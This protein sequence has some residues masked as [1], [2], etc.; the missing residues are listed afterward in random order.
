MNRVLSADGTPIA[1]ERTGSGPVVVLV[2]DR[3]P[4]ALLAPHFTVY[5]YDRR[6]CGA[7]GDTAPY[8][9]KREIEDLEALISEAGGTAAVYGHATG[10]VLALEAA[11]VLPG[12]TRL[13]LHHDR[14]LAALLTT[15]WTDVTVPTLVVDTPAEL[16]AFL[17]HAPSGR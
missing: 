2:G 4:A 13:A 11:R 7:S 9:V 1:Y 16:H 3:E 17:D 5:T 10:A 12:I 14:L 15:R 8:H 6:G